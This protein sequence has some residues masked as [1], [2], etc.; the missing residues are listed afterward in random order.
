MTSSP[1]ALNRPAW[2]GQP[3]RYEVW[4]L[5]LNA[6]EADTSAWLRY[7]LTARPDGGGVAELWAIVDRAGQVRA[8]KATCPLAELVLHD[9]PFA[10]EHP[11]GRLSLDE[12]TGSAGPIAWALSWQ[13]SQ[14]G[15][16][17]LPGWTA[18]L[19]FPRSQVTTPHPD[20]R[21]DGWLEVDGQRLILEGA[22]GQQGHV[23][24]REHAR[25]WAWAHG[26]AVEGLAWEALSAR[27]D[28][29]GR[30]SPAA[31]VVL[32]RHAGTELAFRNVLV[33]RASFQVGAFSFEARAGGYRIQ[34]TVEGGRPVAVAYQDP[35]GTELWCHNTKRAAST[36]ELHHRG[37]RL[38]RWEDPGATALEVGQR[39]RQVGTEAVL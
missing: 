14:R 13:P 39:E 18:R 22:P 23:W 10:V 16:R 25:A 4:Y 34:G 28:V 12:A 21:I 27:V 29:L 6:L 2:Q 37:E 38:G 9:D 32:A 31:T 8:G 3:G 17:H 26:N 33:N 5:K 24:G 36:V 15:W 19:P 20:L 30:P 1:Q 11:D 35:D 7:T